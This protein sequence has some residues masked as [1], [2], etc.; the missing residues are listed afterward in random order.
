MFT[1]GQAVV[2]INTMGRYWQNITARARLLRS[3]AN[4]AICLF[5]PDRGTVVGETDIERAV[6]PVGKG[7]DACQVAYA[8]APKKKCHLLEQEIFR[9]RE[10]A[11]HA[12]AQPVS[13]VPVMPRRL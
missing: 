8:S 9:Y 4:S 13:C 1:D 5:P 7:I 3:Y 10:N 12:F 11:P 2:Q 6:P